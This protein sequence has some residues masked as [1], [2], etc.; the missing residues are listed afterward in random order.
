MLPD[1]TVT[2]G[3]DVTVDSGVADGT[4][5]TNQGSVVSEQTVPTPT[6]ADGAR[7][8]GF[9][10]TEIPV[11]PATAHALSVTK[12]AALTDDTVAP[13]GT[14]NEG[15]EV[16]YDIVLRNTGSSDLTNLVFS[17]TVPSG[18]SPAGM[19]VTAV[20]TTQGT[21]PP[22]SN[23]I[24]ISDIGTLAPNGT[25]VITIVGTANGT[26]DVTNQ[27]EV[28]S[29]EL[30]P[31]LSDGDGDPSNGAQPTVFPVLAAGVS[32][33]PVLA[34]DKRA[35]LIG[36]SNG[37]GYANPGETLRFVVTLRNTGSAPATD[38][39]FSDTLD[40]SLGTLL[41]DS[42]AISQGVL[43]ALG[44]PL[45]I[46]VGTLEPGA[47][48]TVSYLV[49]ADN[50]G[51]M[52]NSAEIEDG[53]GNKAEA[54]AQV[55]I[56]AIDFGDLP[57]TGAGTGVGNYQTLLSDDGARHI[58]D[59]SVGAPLTYLGSLL[60]A[61]A[62]G[63]PNTTATGD[64]LADLNDEDGVTFTALTAGSVASVD[65]VSSAAGNVLNAWI[66]FN[67]DGDFS[68]AGEQI[69]SDL[70][71][72]AGSN[73]IGYNVPLGAVPGDTGARFRVTAASGQGGDSPTGLA[74]TGEVEDYLVSI[75]TSVAPLG[76]IGN[77]VWLDENGDGIQ[78]AGE[79]G[80]GGVTVELLDGNGAPVLD[81]AGN[82]VVAVTDTDGGYLFPNLPAGDY[83]IRV[84]TQTLPLDNNGNPVVQSQL[85]REDQDFGNQTQLGG[86]GGD[87]YPVSI[88]AGEENLT[89]DFGYNWQPSG[90]VLGNTGPAALGDRIWID[91]NGDGVQDPGEPGVEGVSVT[92]IGAG[93]DG[94]FGTGDDTTATTT[95]GPA[96]D[97]IFNDLP[98][99]A[100]TVTVDAANFGAGQPLEGYTPD[101]RPGRVRPA[102]D[103]PGQHHHHGGGAG[104]R[105]RLPERRLRLP[106]AGGTGQQPSATPS[107]LTPTATVP[108]SRA[109]AN[110]A[111]PASPSPC[112]TPTTSRSPPPSPTRTANTCSRVCPT[113]PTPCSSTTPTTY[114]ANSP[115]PT[116]PTAATTTRAPPASAAAWPTSTKT[117]ATPRPGTW[118]ATV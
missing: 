19:T 83:Q 87:A 95:T 105:R 34:L 1:A 103:G 6:D 33:A 104:P 58:I 4:I 51:L 65:V 90:N 29:T 81:G 72:A 99:G 53:A 97:Y 109:T 28:N 32:G 78:D 64:N 101:R 44:P 111:S 24:A 42:L 59:G 7:E 84:D 62:N 15:D 2:I 91:A 11:G 47:V 10:P 60:D 55:P 46:N 12:T 71:L 13:I 68:D 92:L 38:V 30:G 20:T 22:A 74:S 88:G 14:I 118:P 48:E 116:T 110:T 98:A 79:P 36:D 76:A 63:Q 8:N 39:Q 52:Q 18:P 41:P 100:Y 23:V 75:A 70:V 73:P 66:D 106:A 86:T 69:I 113:A 57:D 85:A 115:R 117:S 114:S 17:D 89:A 56:L 9:Q 26:G 49:T 94:I 77:R 21:A 107:G 37:D 43:L 45:Q 96:G 93:A 35:E 5:I 67:G 31:V 82:P 40:T 16:T 3:F 61:E 50:L 54:S 112:S 102:G 27:A 80:I 108:T 25:V